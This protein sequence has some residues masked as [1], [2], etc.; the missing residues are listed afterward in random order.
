MLF[1]FQDRPR[2]GYV[3]QYAAISCCRVGSWWQLGSLVLVLLATNLP[4]SAAV[5][6][7][8]TYWMGLDFIDSSVSS[9]IAFL[10][11]FAPYPITVA[12]NY[13]VSQGAFA[14]WTEAQARR[15][16]ALAVEDVYQAIDVGDASRI[17]GL[18][19]H[20]GPVPNSFTGQHLNMVLGQS[21]GPLTALGQTPRPD[22]YDDPLANDTVVAATYLENIDQLGAT[23]VHYGTDQSAINSI[24]GTTAHEIGHVF[25]AEHV[26]TSADDL[27]PLPIMAIEATGLPTEARLRERRFSQN[28]P[29]NLPNAELLLQNIG[30]VVRGDFNLDGLVDGAD[31]GLLLANWGLADRLY[32]EGDANGDH[33]VD[34]ADVSELIANWTWTS[35]DLTQLSLFE[36]L[37]WQPIALEG[38]ISAA[39]NAALVQIPEPTGCILACCAG[40]LLLLGRSGRDCQIHF[41]SSSG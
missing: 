20:L 2:V 41:A 37:T 13:F 35:S 19:I 32:W 4:C 3:P 40:S 10:F 17:L 9:P 29:A 30:T 14:G 6:T 7:S 28:N 39:R 24:A 18:A 11:D 21:T 16:V 33:L 36:E 25:G 8:K 26:T 12:D 23:H 1:K 31:S 5:G 27:E 22:T 38:T 34:G 15:A